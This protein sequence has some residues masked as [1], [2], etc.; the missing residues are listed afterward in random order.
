MDDIDVQIDVSH[1]TDTLL[2]RH[3]TLH[4]ALAIVQG[5]HPLIID[6]IGTG[7]LGG[8][9]LTHGLLENKFRR[10]DFKRDHIQFFH[11]DELLI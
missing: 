7:H 2:G 9:N 8:M 10:H 6:R 4:T 11:H 1:M 5:S 3:L